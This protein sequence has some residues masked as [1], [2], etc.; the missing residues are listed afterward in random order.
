VTKTF[1][2]QLC[3][4]DT[5]NLIDRASRFPHGF[6]SLGQFVPYTKVKHPA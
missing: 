3:S 2:S 6:V 1:G 4:I 5:V